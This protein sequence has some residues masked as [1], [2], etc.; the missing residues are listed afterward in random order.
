MGSRREFTKE[1]KLAVIQQ[2]GSRSAAEI[3]RENNIKQN[4]ICRW[5]KEYDSNPG[6]AFHG[7]GKLWKEEAKIAQYERLIGRLYAEIDLLKKSLEHL[8]QLRAEEQRGRGFTK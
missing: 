6:E 7:N 4:L 8:S 2:L 3:C 1:F 5:K